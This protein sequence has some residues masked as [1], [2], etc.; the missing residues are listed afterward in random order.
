MAPCPKMM[1]LRGSLLPTLHRRKGEGS[2]LQLRNDEHGLVESSTKSAVC[3]PACPPER[4]HGHAGERVEEGLADAHQHAHQA[5]G[6]GR[7][8]KG[9]KA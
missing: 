2:T 3:M 5:A 9:R 4:P 1:E 6:G 8:G 7:Q